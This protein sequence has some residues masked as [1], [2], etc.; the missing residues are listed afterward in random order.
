MR[1]T[2]ASDDAPGFR[3]GP[4]CHHEACDRRAAQARVLIADEGPVWTDRFGA[5][6]KHPAVQIEE[7]A[8][9]QFARM[10]RELDL[11]GDPRPDVRPPR[12]GTVR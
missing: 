4:V 3:P 6:R 7:V 11:D 5:P 2:A 9:L 10:M 12:R 1:R 8:R